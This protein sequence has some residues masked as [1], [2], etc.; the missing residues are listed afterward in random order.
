LSVLIKK[1]GGV[2]VL[3][4][5][6]FFFVLLV[7]FVVNT[8]FAFDDHYKCSNETIYYQYDNGWFNEI[9]DCNDYDKEEE[10]NH[11]VVYNGKISSKNFTEVRN[12]YCIDGDS[13][14]NVIIEERDV[15]YE[16]CKGGCNTSTGKCADEDNEDDCSDLYK[17][18]EGDYEITFNNCGE[19]IEEIFC[20][21]GC[22]NHNCKDATCSHGQSNGFYCE[23]NNIVEYV[24]SSDRTHFDHVIR[25]TCQY[26]CKE[27]SCKVAP[28]QEPIFYS[29][30]NGN[31]YYTD[32]CG[33][34]EG[35]FQE[36]K[37][38]CSQDKVICYFEENLELSEDYS[39]SNIAFTSAFLAFLETRGGVEKIA[40]LKKMIGIS[41]GSA[42][43]LSTF[44]EECDP[45]RS[46]MITS[47][48]GK[49]GLY[50][51]VL[52][53][54]HK[55]VDDYNIDQPSCNVTFTGNEEHLH[56]HM[57]FVIEKDYLGRPIIERNNEFANLHVTRKDNCLYLWANPIG[58]GRKNPNNLPKLGRGFCIKKCSEDIDKRGLAGANPFTD[59]HLVT[60]FGDSIMKLIKDLKLD[61]PD[62]LREWSYRFILYLPPVVEAGKDYSIVLASSSFSLMALIDN[63]A[64]S[65]LTKGVWGDIGLS[66][67]GVVIRRL[68]SSGKDNLL[69]YAPDIS[70]EELLNA[71]PNIQYY[72]DMLEISNYL[73]VWILLG[74]D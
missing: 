60:A 34:K 63:N 61:S 24:C 72:L 30:N 73:A 51:C 69:C 9:R 26:G 50:L 10:K 27:A 37:F 57:F 44:K 21:Y 64:I 38:G 7:V 29:C 59:P 45:S 11:C 58:P 14:C 67:N 53:H 40:E 36:C 8:S 20:S 12:S 2:R 54:I 48:D 22:E 43:D 46:G 6:I 4:K 65:S 55:R 68:A 31:I 1:E 23:G 49:Y 16:Q 28:C 32:Y 39:P 52:N 25:E 3:K 41:Y 15:N 70:N 66:Q 33:A 62:I 19:R 71:D 47:T 35:L 18:C 56:I 13:E 42:S 5:I 17:R 74:G